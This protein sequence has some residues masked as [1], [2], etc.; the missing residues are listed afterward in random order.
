MSPR[1]SNDA[2]RQP[3]PSASTPGGQPGQKPERNTDSPPNKPGQHEQEDTAEP[4][5]QFPDAKPTLPR[6]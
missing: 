4:E 6:Q 2:A 3:R 5:G 1:E